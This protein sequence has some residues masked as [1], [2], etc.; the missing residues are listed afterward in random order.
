MAGE[1]VHVRG[2]G[3]SIVQGILVESD[4]FDIVDVRRRSESTGFNIPA[5]ICSKLMLTGGAE[6]GIGA[7]GFKTCG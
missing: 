7:G 3:M 1:L 5:S 2:S 4:I 6:T